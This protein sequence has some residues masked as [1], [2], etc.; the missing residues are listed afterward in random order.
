MNPNPYEPPRAHET[1]GYPQAGYAN[2]YPNSGGDVV[3]VNRTMFILA[4]V[5]AWFASVYW[6][7]LTLLAVI[8]AAMGG[9]S[10]IQVILPCYLIAMYA[11]R[12]FQIVKGDPVAAQKIVLL[13]VVGAIFAVLNAAGAAS[14]A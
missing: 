12:G 11:I 14:N 3:P 8:G 13:H 5:G 2:G 1:P 6:A 9:G 10:F 7:I 4:A